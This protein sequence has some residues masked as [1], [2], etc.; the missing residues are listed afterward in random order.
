MDYIRY[1]P[2]GWWTRGVIE[3]F[4]KVHRTFRYKESPGR[5]P[6][7]NGSV[8][9]RIISGTSKG[10]LSLSGLVRALQLPVKSRAVRGLF[11]KQAYLRYKGIAGIAA[12]HARNE[13]DTLNW[14]MEKV[15]W[16]QSK[17][18]RIV[19]SNEKIYDLNGH[20][21]LAYK[22]H[23][24]RREKRWISKRRNGG[25]SVMVWDFF[26]CKKAF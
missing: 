23:D 19:W 20:C 2:R 17:S 5:S 15:T 16:P 22:W 11:S 25:G 1:F 18:E 8:K 9:R 21:G 14:A 24:L 13:A 7:M 26:R 3:N 12:M 4:F 10:V 6:K